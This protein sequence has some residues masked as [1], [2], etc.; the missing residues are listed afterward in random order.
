MSLSVSETSGIQLTAQLM[1]QRKIMDQQQAN[2]LQL[3]ES[4]T[5]V[6]KDAQRPSDGVRGKLLD[7]IG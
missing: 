7:V 5:A 4:A 3:I 2:A 1:I 6:E